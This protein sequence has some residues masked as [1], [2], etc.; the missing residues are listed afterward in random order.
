MF[1]LVTLLMIFKLKLAGLPLQLFIVN[2]V[3]ALDIFIYL[4]L[5]FA[6][7][8]WRCCGI[9][10]LCI[11]RKHLMAL[12]LTM[13]FIVWLP[14]LILTS[15]VGEIIVGSFRSEQESFC[16]SLK[17]E[18]IRLDWEFWH[19]LFFWHDLWSKLHNKESCIN[20]IL[21]LSN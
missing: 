12:M 9:I 5:F 17:Y 11:H 7:A 1:F 4:F 3:K 19:S 2:G 10:T 8:A 20:L 16:S 15:T 21:Q 18:A 14:N 6:L 13:A